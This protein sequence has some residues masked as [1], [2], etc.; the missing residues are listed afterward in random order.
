VITLDLI[1]EGRV[2]L[3]VGIGYQAAD[4]Q[5]FGVPMGHRLALF[6]EGDDGVSNG[7]INRELE[8]LKR[9]FN[10]ALQQTPPKS[11]QKPYIPMLQGQNVRKGFSS[12]MNLWPCEQP[13]R[14]RHALLWPLPIT[15]D[16]G[17]RRAWG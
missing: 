11:P 13:Y 4:F 3:G 5:A 6:E 12:M 17:N 16:G 10:L 1:S 2:I 15:R 14:A 9:M 7:E 8:A